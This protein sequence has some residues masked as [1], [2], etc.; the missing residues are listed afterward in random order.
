MNRFT[1]GP[2]EIKSVHDQDDSRAIYIGPKSR[3]SSF[4]TIRDMANGDI[5]WAW[6]EADANAELIVEAPEMFKQ[7]GDNLQLLEQFKTF[8]ETAGLDFK[9]PF[10]ED[11]INNT[12][13][14][15]DKIN[16]R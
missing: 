16:N 8:R 13:K 9:N 6:Y 7:L 2:W 3:H 12:R 15:L 1:D 11:T 5:Q 4:A 10:L 14:L